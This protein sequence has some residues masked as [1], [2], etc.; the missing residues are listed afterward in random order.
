MRPTVAQPPP[1]AGVA[2]P[3][4]FAPQQPAHGMGSIMRP[5]TASGTVV[6]TQQVGAL[7]RPPPPSLLPPTLAAP[8]PQHS[9]GIM[10]PQRHA[11]APPPA[12]LPGVQLYN[13][14]TGAP[15]PQLPGAAAPVIIRNPNTGAPIYPPGHSML[16]MQSVH[17]VPRPPAVQPPP[18]QPQQGQPQ[19]Q[20]SQP[21]PRGGGGGWTP[22][23]GGGR[24]R[25]VLAPPAR[26]QRQR[27]IALP[28]EKITENPVA[29]P[30]ASA[31]EAAEVEQ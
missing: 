24:P 3:Q 23:R 11:Q 16:L 1:A 21:L 26:R 27:D 15:I 4:Q 2:Y 31:A 30:P 29:R 5:M 12:S 14:N 7:S 22:G 9:H 13:P 17:S 20:L 6:R 28:P 18:N 8:S 10:Q 19:Q 25:P